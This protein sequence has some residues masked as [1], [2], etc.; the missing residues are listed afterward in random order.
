MKNDKKSVTNLLDEILGPE[1]NNTQY[2]FRKIEDQTAFLNEVDYQTVVN[3]EVDPIDEF[4]WWLDI[5]ATCL[6][7]DSFVLLGVTN[8]V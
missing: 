5:S 4:I 6:S 7:L 1:Y 2:I 3:V 8:C